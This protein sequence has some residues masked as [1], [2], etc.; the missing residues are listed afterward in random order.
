MEIET[1]IGEMARS[2]GVTDGPLRQDGQGSLTVTNSHAQFYEQT[3]RKHVFSVFTALAGTTI[4]SGNVAPPAAAAATVISLL[5]PLGSQKNLEIL[6]GVLLHISGTPA[7]GGWA[8]CMAY[9]GVS[10]TAAEAVAQKGVGFLGQSGTVAKAWSQTAL[11]GGIVHVNTRL[12][13]SA[14]IAAALGTT[15]FGTIDIDEVM[16]ALIVPPGW[17]LTLAPPGTGTS[18]VVA[19]SIEYAEVPLVA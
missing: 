6:R 11:T 3:F 7:A 1:I 15:S 4:V 18:H 19:A 14:D 16:G 8:W 13:P 17:M 10:V 12:F 5:N 2:D 9:Q